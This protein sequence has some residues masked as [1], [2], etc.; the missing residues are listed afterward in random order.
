MCNLN[1]KILALG[2]TSVYSFIIRHF[3]LW[4]T[5]FHSYFGSLLSHNGTINGTGWMSTTINY[6]AQNLAAPFTESFDFNYTDEC[7]SWSQKTAFYVDEE[8]IDLAMQV[9]L[10]FPL[11]PMFHVI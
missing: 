11:S 4:T 10:K 1:K 3:A 5:N 8:I 9:C 7:G 6:T 2:P